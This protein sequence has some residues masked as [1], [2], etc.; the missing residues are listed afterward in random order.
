MLPGPTAASLLS[1]DPPSLSWNL[2]ASSPVASQQR[3]LQFLWEIWSFCRRTSTTY[4][5]WPHHPLRSGLS[6]EAGES[7][8]S[9]LQG[10][11]SPALHLG[12]ISFCLLSYRIQAFVILP[13]SIGNFLFFCGIV[14]ISMQTS[15][16]YLKQ[17]NTE[18]VWLHSSL[19]LLPHFHWFPLRSCLHSSPRWN[20]L[21]FSGRPALASRCEVLPLLFPS[22]LLCYFCP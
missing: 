4:T 22:P 6:P 12:C 19:Q 18:T 2:I 21:T 3:T 16:V 8:P 5:P 17:T 11:L 1:D 14:H 7:L 10:L 13:S 9:F 20:T 15:W